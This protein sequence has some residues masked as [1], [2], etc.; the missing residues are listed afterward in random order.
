MIKPDVMTSLRLL[1]ENAEIVHVIRLGKMDQNRIQ[2]TLVKLN[3]ERKNG[4]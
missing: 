3:D 2:P 4:K 1:E